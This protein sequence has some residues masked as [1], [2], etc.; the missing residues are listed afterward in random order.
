VRS[1]T[2]T[3]VGGHGPHSHVRAVTVQTTGDTQ[4]SERSPNVLAKYSRP[5]KRRSERTGV[6]S[7][8]SIVHKPIVQT[9]RGERCK[10]V[11]RSSDP[12]IRQASE[13]TRTVIVQVD[14]RTVVRPTEHA[15]AAEQNIALPLFLCLATGYLRPC[16]RSQRSRRR[17]YASTSRR[18]SSTLPPCA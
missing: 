17:R 6:R 1:I 2:R 5:H 12:A 7:R 15:K 8:R 14:F 4:R 13:L 3:P 11:K 9:Q 16:R 10:G 18:R